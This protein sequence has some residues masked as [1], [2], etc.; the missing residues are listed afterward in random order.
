MGLRC[1]DQEIIPT[2]YRCTPVYAVVRFVK[3]R[4]QS[5]FAQVGNECV[6]TSVCVHACMRTSAHCVHYRETSVHCVCMCHFLISII[7]VS[8][9]EKSPT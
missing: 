4:C 3:V 6:N 9:Y 7:Y 1:G 2:V 5:N 8:H